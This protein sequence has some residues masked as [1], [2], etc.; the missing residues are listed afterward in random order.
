MLYF[1]V[2]T[3]CYLK[4]TSYE[5]SVF[6][7]LKKDY[8]KRLGI[9]TVA[10][11]SPSSSALIQR[12]GNMCLNLHMNVILLVASIMSSYAGAR[13]TSKYVSSVALKK[14]FGVLIVAMTA[15]RV[16]TMVAV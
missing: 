14:L 12:I 5:H 7:R 15:H 1:T 4:A 11:C 3:V 16:F 9:N 13:I 10:V 2:F 8:R 6:K